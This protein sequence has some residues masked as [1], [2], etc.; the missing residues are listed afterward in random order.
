MTVAELIAKLQQAPPDLVVYCSTEKYH[1]TY[2]VTDQVSGV[3]HLNPE[4]NSQQKPQQPDPDHTANAY[5]IG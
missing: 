5:I 4:L 2:P 1:D 3:Y